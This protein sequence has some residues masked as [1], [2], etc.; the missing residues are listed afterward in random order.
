MVSCPTWS[1]NLG[2]TLMNRGCK[3]AG[4]RLRLLVRSD[5]SSL[6]IEVA[7]SYKRNTHKDYKRTHRDVICLDLP[8]RLC[9]FL[10][11]LKP[12]KGDFC[13]SLLPCGYQNKQH[14]TTCTTPHLLFSVLLGCIEVRKPKEQVGCVYWLKHLLIKMYGIG[15]LL[16]LL[17]WSTS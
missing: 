1:K 7:H 3:A 2:R 15:F 4:A 12:T 6:R 8:T 17:G 10:N 13:V 14:W 11:Q 5:G 16:R 9:F